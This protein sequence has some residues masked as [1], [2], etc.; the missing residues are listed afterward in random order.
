VSIWP[1]IYDAISPLSGAGFETRGIGLSPVTA[2]PHSL[3]ADVSGNNSF[4]VMEYIK[5]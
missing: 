1:A 5:I 3:C 2:P 4:I